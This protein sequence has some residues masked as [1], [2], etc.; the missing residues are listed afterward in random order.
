MLTNIDHISPSGMR[1]LFTCEQ[2]FVHD[3]TDRIAFTSKP[4]ALGNA[5]HKYMEACFHDPLRFDEP[6]AWELS[7]EFDVDSFDR[8]R[9]HAMALGYFANKDPFE[10]VLDIELEIRSGLFM[11]RIDAVIENDQGKWIVD[12]KTS[13]SKELQPIELIINNP[14]MMMYNR[15]RTQAIP[16]G[17]AGICYRVIH[18]PGE[19]PKKQESWQ[20]FR[21]RLAPV[22]V[23]SVYL[24]K[25][26]FPK[27]ATETLW[28]TA[29]SLV[30]ELETREPRRNLFACWDC[31]YRSKCFGN[32]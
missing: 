3:K 5:F 1:T 16:F 4:L 26:E 8:A 29:L 9:L 25:T 18:K 13:S 32:T 20:D 28:K 6:R 2:K 17:Y 30:T 14:Q 27:D 24:K 7:K 23:S 10:R 19:R 31:Q 22:Q 21:D 15:F 12:L 11:G